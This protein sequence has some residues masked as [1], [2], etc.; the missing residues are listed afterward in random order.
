MATAAFHGLPSW[1]M[2]RLL[3]MVNTRDKPSD[4]QI[5]RRYNH[6]PCTDVGELL[7]SRIGKKSDVARFFHCVVEHSPVACGSIAD[8]PT[9]IICEQH[10]FQRNSSVADE[11]METSA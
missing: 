6:S 1:L 11:G 5:A 8:G 2:T 7:R 9:S 3:L 10:V 4:A